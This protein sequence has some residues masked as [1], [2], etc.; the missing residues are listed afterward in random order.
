MGSGG[1]RALRGRRT[2]IVTGVPGTL[3][4]VDDV[5]ALVLT[6]FAVARVV[7][8]LV[9]DGLPLMERLR[10]WVAAHGDAWEYLTMCP[11]C[12]AVWVSAPAVALLDWRA[13]VPMP[14]FAAAAVAYVAG[15]LVASEDHGPVEPEER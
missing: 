10:S 3:A 11:W 1:G 15:R 12:V 9:A 13:S 4:A 8:L 7:R 6:T 5:L 2:P 14:V